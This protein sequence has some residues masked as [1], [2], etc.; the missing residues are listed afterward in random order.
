V[1]LKSPYLVKSTDVFHCEVTSFE[2]QANTKKRMKSL[3]CRSHP[4]HLILFLGPELLLRPLLLARL[5]A[6]PEFG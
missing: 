3:L 1:L 4:W 6:N 5:G 2:G